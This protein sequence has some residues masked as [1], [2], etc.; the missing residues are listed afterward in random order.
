MKSRSWLGAVSLFCLAVL[1][2][3]SVTAGERIKKPKPTVDPE[4]YKAFMDTQLKDVSELDD[5]F[6]EQQLDWL[7]I[8]PPAEDFILRQ[9]SG[10][11]LPFVW[12]SFPPE[13]N[14]NLVLRYENSV[15]AYKVWVTVDSLTKET[16]FY[17]E[18]GKEI[19]ALDSASGP[20]GQWF[21]Q[22]CFP[23]LFSGR[24]NAKYVDYMSRLYDPARLQVEVTLI[25][26][27][28]AEP[29][30]YVQK[31]ASEEITA[32]TVNSISALKLLNYQPGQTV[33]N[34]CMA[35]ERTGSI[36]RL[37]VA[38]PYNASTYPTNCFTNR[39]DIFQT[40]DLLESWWE[41]AVT[42]N[43]NAA[44]NCVGWTDWSV[45]NSWVVTRYYTAAN[46]NT[47]SDGDGFSNGRERFMYH[48]DPS[49][50]ASRPVSVS[51][52]LAYS[53]IETGSLYML[54]T[55]VSDSWSI[56][57]SVAI[58]GPGAYSNDRVAMPRSWWFK[59]F[60]DANDSRQKDD[61]EPWASYSASSMY[62]TSSLGG[63]DMTLQD[64]SSVWGAL[65]YTGSV[66]GDIWVVAVTASNSWDTAYHCV[67]PWVQSVGES[68]EVAYVSFPASYSIIGMPA[69]NYWI[70]AFV[71]SDTNEAMA[72]PEIVGEYGQTAIA[73]SH[74]RTGI[75]ITLEAPPIVRGNVNY[76][77]H[78]GGQTGTIHVVAVTTSNSCDTS[79]SQ[80]LDQPGDYELMDV[81]EES[82]WIWAWR[83]TDGD[84]TCGVYEAR[85]YYTNEALSVTGLLENAHIILT[86]PD[87]DA[88]GLG[89]WWEIKWF[90]GITNWNGTDDPD[91]D[92]L[93]NAG[94]YSWGANPTFHDTDGDG[95]SDGY[96]VGTGFDPLLY[97]DAIDV[98]GEWILPITNT[99]SGSEHEGALPTYGGSP[100]PPTLDADRDGMTDK[101]ER[102]AGTDRY[103]SNS[104]FRV[105]NV[106][107][108][109]SGMTLQWLSALDREYKVEVYVCTNGYKTDTAF[110]NAYSWYDGT[111]GGLSY[112]SA[113]S[114]QQV[115]YRLKVRE[116]DADS[117]GLPDWWEKIYWLNLD[118]GTPQF[119]DD[120]D[121]V[122]NLLEYMNETDPTAGFV[123][124]D[125][126]GMSDDW[127]KCYKLDL[128][129]PS[130]A[131]D[132]TDGDGWTNLEEYN[133]GTDPTDPFSHPSGGCYV[134]TNGTDAVGYGSYTNPY[135]TISYA[136]SQAGSNG[137][138]IILPGLYTGATNRDISF[139]GK[140]L[141]V[142]GVQGQR[143][144]TVIDCE[145]AG[146]GFLI[147]NGET[148]VVIRHL[149]IQNGSVPYWY[150]PYRG[151]AI[152]AE[153]ESLAL[154]I[155]DCS[156]IGNKAGYSSSSEGGALYI[157]CSPI[158]QIS[159]C[160]FEQNE[161]GGGGAI[162]CL[163]PLSLDH[164]I[165]KN[166]KGSDSG[167]A[168]SSS[169]GLTIE[170]SLIKGNHGGYQN[171]GA[172]I[173]SFGGF[174]SLINCT[175]SE[176]NSDSYSALLRLNGSSAGFTNCI[177]NVTTGLLVSATDATWGAAY[178]CVY[179]AT[180]TNGPG[181]FV[182]D[183]RFRSD[184]WH[185]LLDSPC[186]DT[187]TNL[188][189][190]AAET[191]IDGSPRI[192]DG[193]VD[194]GADEISVHYVAADS[195][196]PVSP[197]STWATAATTI[198]AAVDAAFSY[199]M[200]F[201]TNG[202]YTVGGRAVG[203]GVLCRIALTNANL[204]V[205]SVNG[206]DVTR[207]EGAGPR[208]A[209]AVRCAYIGSNAVLDGFT[210]SQGHT[211][212]NGSS[213]AQD[214]GGTWC[215]ES[216]LVTNCT[217][218]D[219]S[220]R[221]GGGVYGGSVVCSIIQ[222]NEAVSGGGAYECF[223]ERTILRGNTASENGGAAFGGTVYSCSVFSNS[224]LLGGGVYSAFVE[225][226]T[227][228][229]NS[230]TEN[231]GGAL[232]GTL[233]SC[234]VF[235]NSALTGGGAYSSVVENCT[236][237]DN[238][239]EQAGGTYAGSLINSIVYYNTPT[240]W[241]GG[242]FTNCC[243]TPLPNGTNNLVAEP[244]LL[245]R[246]DGNY[247][248]RHDSICIN[249]GLT[250]LWMACASDLAGEPRVRTVVEIGA[251]EYYGPKFAHMPSY[252]QTNTWG[253]T[254]AGMPTHIWSA[255]FDFITNRLPLLC[256]FHFG[257]GQQSTTTTVS[258]VSAARYIGTT[259]TYSTTSIYGVSA[260]IH[261]NLGVTVTQT[262]QLACRATND[263]D[264][265]VSHAIE[266]GLVWLYVNAHTNSSGFYWLHDSYPDYIASANGMAL[267]AFESFGHRA[268]QTNDVYAD[269]VEQGLN[270]L[271]TACLRTASVSTDQCRYN[272][273][274]ND[275]G[276]GITIVNTANDN[277]EM[278][279]LGSV[280]TAIVCSSE[281]TN[282]AP[283]S[284]PPSICDRTYLDILQ[285]MVDYCA[286]A[287][288]DDGIGRG[289]WRYSANYA[290]SDNSASWWPVTGMHYA[291]SWAGVVIP[292]GLK[293]ELAYWVVY[294]QNT[295]GAFGYDGPS[296]LSAARTCYGLVQ[297]AF[298]NRPFTNVEVQAALGYLNTNSIPNAA[299]LYGMHAFS[300]ACDIFDP[301]VEMVGT[302]SWRYACASMLLSAQQSDGA[303]VGN[304]A[305]RIL[306]IASAIS[307]L[308]EVAP[309]RVIVT[310]VGQ[311]PTNVYSNTTV[312][313]HAKVLPRTDISNLVLKTWYC[314]GT[315][316]AFSLLSMTNA[317]NTY[318]T[319]T[320][321]PPQPS[322]TKV[323]YFLE[324]AYS[325][326]SATFTQRYPSAY[327]N[328]C[329][330]YLV[331][332]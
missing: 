70:R 17:N 11:T 106:V 244:G 272:P 22:A 279:E 310:S 45:T 307:T 323:E 327:S 27:E 248:L 264:A 239:A 165:L 321:I 59:A 266:D 225:R 289:G 278:Y 319:A 201:V 67:I 298:Q 213:L 75:D 245:G 117:D 299:D 274:S 243:A 206:P 136:F 50:S 102:A 231:G 232:Y 29:Y 154:Q 170:N 280:M 84:L 212:E 96:E 39:L 234:L 271:F 194:I 42:T 131:D 112:T 227:I 141:T 107:R 235:S 118:D 295:N 162:R 237:C 62:V 292:E 99:T 250:E 226:T 281:P 153:S 71:D 293:D 57:C 328:H 265:R 196:N 257:D 229:G 114:P 313:I 255:A 5:W 56:G 48:S 104:Y 159:G 182:A 105:T 254:V 77:T 267:T 322:Q 138:V 241:E 69:T 304:Y 148:N 14:K 208:G 251:Y 37:T 230:A 98:P 198:Q 124:T 87:T 58:P 156:F 192:L 164:S 73:V 115:F 30:L 150:S 202:V 68:G 65:S 47:D 74:R 207:I 269:V 301:P 205:Q 252:D 228:S 210:L 121:K 149:I 187:G 276:F 188:S 93:N 103:D 308:T 127:E 92:D 139:N 329:F 220:A 209:G 215:E 113:A 130:D 12:D 246:S 233:R 90:G 36:V 176:N 258:S 31:A 317:A 270:Y 140:N 193:I 268:P 315:N 273:D 311:N 10:Q 53:G 305:G 15:P 223:A 38:Y 78:S 163:S 155:N 177:F 19:F 166:N 54:A 290:S 119:D 286:W 28:Y 287:Q 171:N 168:I 3:L 314:A 320:P 116:K 6:V 316:T 108:K 132:D 174:V 137:H 89:D 94:E 95:F 332:Q 302:Q 151:G 260:I 16:L 86:D 283:T 120:G 101:D 199:S 277:C 133:A 145:S 303:W 66:D 189:D 169:S 33:T 186:R 9:P 20:A 128:F 80:S 91:D 123:D 52:A 7:H 282:T 222:S 253:I 219:C 179:G 161:A 184:G 135:Q 55:A 238:S 297:L 190:F 41:L 122:S 181:N 275:N 134:A 143:D 259:H 100:Y 285:D 324:A 242:V 300:T 157:S 195:P 111:G 175:L 23:D 147:Q 82:C 306:G 25:P 8:L 79:Y 294:S 200:I 1:L 224:A 142:T 249:A 43:A 185:L 2:V 46:G 263:F 261:D 247:A 72:W 81:P 325:V 44:S 85:G 61:W 221:F 262:F 203:D 288:T 13:F 291:E 216:G 183:P 204:V 83:D 60:C 167:S 18:D 284:A 146:Q 214:G 172:T 236:I 129:D 144:N 318:Y 40:S 180:L 21:L 256:W 158:A 160:L 125:G 173:N 312:S 76:E 110:S 4:A 97:G 126:D 178:C 296:T 24:Y 152:L 197:Y 191:D 88:D 331:S 35:I 217:F 32:S 64:V 330:S 326:V 63:I 34:I 309:L 211:D 51:G 109:A 218:M 240:N 49:N 26:S